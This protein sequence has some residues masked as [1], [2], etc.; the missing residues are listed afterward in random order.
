MIK[1]LPSKIFQ[2]LSLRDVCISI[3]ILFY[4]T[5]SSAQLDSKHYLPPL[6][7]TSGTDNT[8][9]HQSN[10]AI[11]QQSIYLST[12]ETT[13]FSV[14]VYRGTSTIPWMVIPSLVKGAPFVID[15]VD[16]SAGG[17][18]DQILADSNNNITLVTNGN[19]GVV[20]TNAG[21]RFEAPGGQK[22]YVNYRGRSGAQAGSLT[23]KG[24]KALG[25]EFRWG[26][27][28]NRHSNANSSTSL[29]IMAT[30]P[31]TIVTISGFNPDCA[32]RNGTDPDGITDDIINITLQAGETYVLEAVRNQGG[33][34]AT[35]N[36][37]N[38]D[39]WLGA[40]ITATEPIAI[41]SGGLNFGISATSQS[42]DV[43]IDQP[44]ATNVI[45]RE[46]VFM[47]GAGDGNDG[48]EFP[49]IV[50]TQDDTQVFAGGTLI[51]TID[52]GEYLEI[53]DSNYS[54]TTAGSNM[55]VRTSKDAYAY[56][57]LAGQT[58]RI[59]TVGMNFI[60][61]VNCLLPNSLEEIPQIQDIASANSNISA[62]T[63]VASVLINDADVQ[64]FQNNVQITTPSSTLVNDG[65]AS[66]QWKTF[67]VPGLSGEIS[68][69]TPG[70]I[71]VGTFMSL[72]SNAGLA[73]YF[74]GFDTVPVVE[75]QLTGGGCHPGSS[76]EEVTGGFAN[77]AWYKGTDEISGTLLAS[78][79][80]LQ[81]YNPTLNGVGDYFVRVTDFGGCEYNSAVVSFYSCDPELQVTKVDN[82]DPIDAGSNVTFTITAESFSVDPITN[83]VIED[84]LPAELEFV[85]AN[86]EPGTTFSST[87]TLT[88]IIGGMNPGDKFELEIVARARDDASGTV[89][90]TITYNYTEI[91]GEVNNLPDDLSE[92]VTINPCNT[93]SAPSS[94]P[95]L[96][97]NTPLTNITHSTT[98]ATGIG[99]PTGLPSGVTASWSSDTITI[100][101]TPTNS[102]IF[103]YNIPL[104]GGCNTINATGTITVNALPIANP[105]TGLDEVCVGGS[106]DLTEGTT[107]S[108]I[109]WN[110]SNTGV[111]TIDTNGLVT[112]VSAGSTDI[113]YTVTD[114]NGCTS[115]ASATFTIT[116]NPLPSLISLSSNTPICEGN[117]A[118]FT[119]SGSANAVLTYNIN[120]NSNQTVTLD[121]SG[122]ATI[123]STSATSDVTINLVSLEASLTSCSITLTNSE[124]VTINP[125]P[126]LASVND[127]IVCDDMSGTQSLDAN[128]GITLNPNTS[129]VWY[130]APSGG[131]IVAS[132]VVNTATPST[133]PPTSFY[134]EI[135]DTSSSCVNPVREEV[136]LQIVS[137][138]F[139]NLSETVCSDEML[140][141]GL[142]FATTYTVAS[143]DPTNVPA[144]ANRTTATTA[145]ITDTY[146]NTT[147]SPVTITY[148]VTI[149]DGSPCDGNIFDV[150]VT[151]NP[152]PSN[153]TAP[154][155]TICSSSTL[156]H[157]LNSDVNVSGS[158]FMWSATDN[159]NVTGET[160]SGGT[161]SI[162]SDTLINNSGTNQI[163][164]YTIIPTNGNGCQGDSFTYT[165]TIKP[166]ISVTAQPLATQTICVGAVPTDLSVTVTGGI[167]G[168]DYQW[169]SSTTS[170]SGFTDISGATSATY[171]P[172]TT[173]SGTTYYQV[174]ISDSSGVC[175]DLTST[176]SVVIINEDPAITS[177]P[178][179]T[180]TI[181]VGAV[182]TDLSVTA[183]GGVAGLTYQWQSSAI[184]SS[185]FTDI[186][187]ATSA[188][189][190]PVTTSS[191]TTYY[192]VVI[193][194]TGSGC[195]DVTSTE[196]VVIINEDPAITSQPLST[197]TICVGAVPTDLS[198]TAT[199][200]VAGLTY[201][202]QSSSTSGSGFTDISGATSATYTPVTTSSGTT[203]YQ[204][205]IS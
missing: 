110:S 131:N 4:T 95:T 35:V 128:S 69:I 32:F 36:T 134:A 108:T 138:P 13:A 9:N 47:R 96:C 97:V 61:P 28:A 6:K 63:I 1:A 157:D 41:A 3:L 65:T 92:D 186:S 103:N 48:T 136:K 52:N 31:N 180:Q 42:R 155:E 199:G 140:N 102:G 67:Y 46:Y 190:T 143:S 40:T 88:W 197:Q 26:G 179:S 74:S 201:Q 58:N 12:P 123:I 106:I 72:G 130:D 116:V 8:A 198:V 120:G 56:Q 70:P 166:E 98:L 10:A 2:R 50:A 194:D 153:T 152:E 79:P 164:T 109:I 202:W 171:T 59:Q 17:F 148:T 19:T 193:S 163:V 124:T 105:I 191:G 54:G 168:L 133:D 111:A 51:G 196:S 62:L 175:S 73:G 37:A 89:T 5:L 158:S 57:C 200:G 137:P 104:T 129:V 162:I 82:A 205:V 68:V 7:Q 39:G 20:L 114:T 27:I 160:V 182:P 119:I 22:F 25:K 66:P 91:A 185:G 144:A 90:N 100:S 87:G 44:V 154:T 101:G 55:Y 14:N 170:G 49:V 113:T 21:L 141:I 15:N 118:E 80:A 60:A 121:G 189:Y 177:Q 45:G 43:G 127:I 16:D 188:T 169:Q 64:I 151:V 99:I 176:E 142:S 146:T 85:S 122:E 117:N 203:Y 126:T 149:Q 145:N 195:N 150:V 156:G 187:G 11:Q 107:G 115:L 34:N 112:G 161:N 132:P 77:Y 29:G 159:S 204:V 192:Q 30:Q 147:G 33:V 183:T 18:I 76:I 53:P 71:A 181:C 165:V 24:G 84:V 83:V 173:S 178:L 125:N 94:T 38:V 135:S 139:P 86:P 75:V 172:V 81:S 23:C 174:I 93:A 184:S 78:G 167:D